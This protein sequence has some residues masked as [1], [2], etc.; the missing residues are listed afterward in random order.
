MITSATTFLW[1]MGALLPMDGSTETLS[2]G[3]AGFVG[4]EWATLVMHDLGDA[5]EP[6]WRIGAR[7]ASFFPEGVG[8]LSKPIYQSSL[9]TEISW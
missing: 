5:L 2:I 9:R 8:I 7:W 1:R 6:G 3:K 4:T